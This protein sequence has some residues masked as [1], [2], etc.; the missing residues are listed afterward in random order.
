MQAMCNL[1]QLLILWLRLLGASSCPHPLLLLLLNGQ[2][3]L[4]WA[5]SRS[6]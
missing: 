4:Q 1:R 6:V 5:A 3:Y 2:I